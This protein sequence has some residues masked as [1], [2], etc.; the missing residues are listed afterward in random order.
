[1]RTASVVLVAAMFLLA[2]DPSA[3]AQGSCSWSALGSG[4]S[5]PISSANVGDL[6]VFDDGTGPALYAGGS[7][8]HAGGLPANWI[9]R[10]DG[11]SWSSLGGGMNSSVFS[12]TVFDDGTGPALYA[13]GF[14]SIA[15]GVAAIRI[16]KWDGASW[17]S[18]GSGVA[19]GLGGGVSALTVFDDGTGPALYA[20]GNFTVA[21]GFPASRIARW[22]CGSTIS[23]SATQASPGATVFV[24]N[25]NLT[26]GNAYFNVFSFDLCPGGP[27]TGQFG[28]LCVTTPGNLQFM[29]SQLQMPLE[30]PLG[31]FTA[32]SSYVNW[33]PLSVPPLT[34]DGVCFDF[35]G[36]VLG[37]ISP[38]TRITIQ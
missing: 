2:A 17:S 21:G 25:T 32:P 10:W 26:P 18:L 6:T 3:S 11:I 33:G 7:F 28:G 24:N 30:T 8:T 15:G 38:V 20:G 35:T 23:I 12:L 19:G 1:M 14:F 36:G 37:P 13:G 34:V 5:L 22:P 9:A 29:L 27:G 31:H 16:A 4:V